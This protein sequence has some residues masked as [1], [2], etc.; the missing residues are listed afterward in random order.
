MHNLRCCALQTLHGL[1]FKSYLPHKKGQKKNE[2]RDKN[3][4]P[5]QQV[6]RAAQNQGNLPNRES[7]FSSL[8][9]Q[10]R[11][12]ATRDAWKDS[13]LRENYKV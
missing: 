7:I 8:D 12:E 5:M 13:H 2:Q 6:L 10:R 1:I 9:I 11:G 4:I 3:E